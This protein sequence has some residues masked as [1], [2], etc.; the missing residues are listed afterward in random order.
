LI[1]KDLVWIDQ[2]LAEIG[3]YLFYRREDQ[4]LILPPNRVYKVNAPAGH[5]LEYLLGGGS[6]L[7]VAGVS[8]TAV[9]SIHHFFISL[10]A[11][12]QG[13]LD[14]LDKQTALEPVPFDFSFTQHP[15]LGEIAVTYRCNLRCTFCYAGCDAQAPE[16]K[17]MTKGEV[18]RIIEIFHQDARIPFFSFT[19]G[20]PLLRPE[21]EEWI[22]YAETLGLRT[23]L[24]SNGTLATPER[25]RALYKAGL[26][27]AQISLEAVD[28]QVH[29]QLTGGDGSY[30]KTLQGIANLQAAGIRV[31]TNTTITQINREEAQVLP[32]F[33]KTLGIDRFAMN[34]CIP[35]GRGKDQENLKLSYSEMPPVIENI[36]QGALR[37]GLTFYWYS[38][39]PH[40]IYNPIA[41][42]MGNKSC[43]AVDGLISVSPTGEVLPCS[44]YPEPLG[45]LLVAGFHKVWFSERGRW[46]KEKKFAPEECGGCDSFV[47]CQ[48]ACPLYWMQNS[49]EEITR[50]LEDKRSRA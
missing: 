27:T 47:A 29:D 5:L 30:D 48:G 16:E 41:A 11:A 2:Y 31:Q 26:R 25:S 32:A 10:K 33:L 50:A 40:C 20:E 23:N 28:P 22:N 34:L 4:V 35:A 8:P 38:P 39:T 42:G 24:V 3:D 7:K 12:Y 6:I 9:E 37:E 13:T 14:S 19:G 45:N 43:A 36:R 1:Q 15:I 46:F 21:L 49:T 17:E 44:S 18:M